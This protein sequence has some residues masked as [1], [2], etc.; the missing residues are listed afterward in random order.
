MQIELLVPGVAVAKQSAKFTQVGGYIKSYQK[1]HVVDYANYVK[2][3]FIKEYPNHNIVDFK[4]KMLSIWIKE[5]RLIPKSKSK[6]FHK[7]AIEGLLRPITKP[8]TDNIAKNIKDAL[9]KL[10]YPDDSQIVCEHI[11]KFYS[12]NPRVEIKI[13]VVN[14]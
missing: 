11:E 1:K 2:T 3:L 9:N 12:D 5:Y 6:K 13:E 10:A 14:G 4:G 8:D 7:Q